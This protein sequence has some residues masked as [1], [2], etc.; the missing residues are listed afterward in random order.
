MLPASLRSAIFS[1]GPILPLLLYF[2]PSKTD[3]N[4]KVGLLPYMGAEVTLS[5]KLVD[6]RDAVALR[7]DLFGFKGDVVEPGR[8]RAAGQLQYKQAGYRPRRG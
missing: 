5:Q 4:Q 6:R 8:A 2:R 7:G 1:H 3:D